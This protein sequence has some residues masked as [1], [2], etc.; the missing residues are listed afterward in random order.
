MP[1]PPLCTEGST[2]SSLAVKAPVR[3]LQGCAAMSASSDSVK[4]DEPPKVFDEVTFLLTTSR[5]LR[6]KES[7]SLHIEPASR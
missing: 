5:S 7:S 3:R 4:A 1:R 2:R 6:M